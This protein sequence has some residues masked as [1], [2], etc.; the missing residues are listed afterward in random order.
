MQG[1]Q[2]ISKALSCTKSYEDKDISQLLLVQFKVNSQGVFVS[3]LSKKKFSRKQFPTNTVMFAGI[4]E[5]R[6]WP[7]R[8]DKIANPK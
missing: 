1:N 6:C 4:E 7:L 3:D 5:K 8:I 2:A